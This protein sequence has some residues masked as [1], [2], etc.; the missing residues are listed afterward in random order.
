MCTEHFRKVWS[1][2]SPWESHGTEALLQTACSHNLGSCLCK[3]PPSEQRQHSW[4]N[5]APFSH[6]CLCATPNPTIR[7]YFVSPESGWCFSHRESILIYLNPC[8][9]RPG[10]LF[11][12]RWYSL[13]T[14]DE[15]QHPACAGSPGKV[16]HQWHIHHPR[17][18]K[19]SL[20]D[21]SSC[22]IDM[23]LCF[24]KG[25][26]VLINCGPLKGS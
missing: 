21:D 8:I 15:V 24:P 3:T 18:Q 7:F 22:L 10:A 4:R 23:W 17:L 12:F 14:R 13:C 6:L 16:T 26:L 5:G 2:A 9:W 19:V 1:R 11:S 20:V 25:V